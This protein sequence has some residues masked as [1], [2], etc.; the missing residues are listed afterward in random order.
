MIAGDERGELFDGF[1]EVHFARYNGVK[2]FLD[3]GPDSC[4]WGMFV[5]L[6]RFHFVFRS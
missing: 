5:R 2:P 4:D 6:E 3:D 1:G